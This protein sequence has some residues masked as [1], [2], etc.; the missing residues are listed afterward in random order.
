V[1]G[2][3]HEW[4]GENK[5]LGLK[6][7]STGHLVRS[8]VTIPTELSRTHQRLVFAN[9]LEYISYWISSHGGSHEGSFRT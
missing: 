8:P 4:G 1:Q 5:V 2:K 7:R 9:T 6:P 3:Q